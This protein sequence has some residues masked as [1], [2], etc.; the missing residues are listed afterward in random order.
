MQTIGDFLL[1]SAPSDTIRKTISSRAAQ[2]TEEVRSPRSMSL[3]LG[4]TG[5][6]AMMPIPVVGEETPADEKPPIDINADSLDTDRDNDGLIAKG[7]VQ[8]IQGPGMQFM[9]D[10]ARY[11]G[12]S[13]KLSAEGHVRLQH[14]GNEFAG[15]SLVLNTDTRIGELHDVTVKLANNGSQG[16]A[17]EVS[18]LGPDQFIMKQAWFTECNCDPPPWKV[19]ANEIRIDAV[20]KS[21]VASDATFYAGDFPIFWTPWWEQPLANQRKSGFLTPDFRTASG[22]GFE[23]EV[24]Y[25]FNLAPDHDLTVTLRPISNRGVLGQ[26]QV[27]YLGQGYQGSVQT[28]QIRDTQTESWRGLTTL[29]HTDHLWGWKIVARGEYSETRNFINDYHQHLVD[30]A[31]HRMESHVTA[32]KNTIADDGF[33]TM[34][35]GVRWNQDLEATNDRFTVQSLPFAVYSDSLPLNRLPG[36]G[37]LFDGL[38]GNR[39]RLQREF[40]ADNYYQMSGDAVQRLDAAPTLE[41]SRPLGVTRLTLRAQARETSYLIQGD[42]MQTGLQRDDTQHREASMF[43]ANL[44]TR[45]FKIYPG[46]AT[47]TLEPKV[48]VVANAATDQTLLPNYDTTQRYF[49]FS[50]LFGDSLYSGLDRISVGQRVNYALVTRLINHGE[51]EAFWQNMDLGVGQRWIPDDNNIY[52]QGRNFSPIVSALNVTLRGGW[53]IN[54]ANRFNPEGQR[55]ENNSLR[56]V[57]HQNK[58]DTLSLGY[59]YNQPSYSGTLMENAGSMLEDAVVNSHFHFNDQWSWNQEANYSLYQST[60]KSWKTGFGYEHQCWEFTIE[61][62]RKLANDTINHGGGFIGFTLG[63]KGIGDYGA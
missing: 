11:S 29:D 4:L 63:L 10:E 20:D 46:I 3:L 19:K 44:G 49:A 12:K 30:S 43:S 27:R 26:L 56:L 6:L 40:H 16:G 61:G 59:Y 54:A 9:A 32:S 1:I 22:N 48:E 15:R 55:I 5:L 53:E 38:D 34:R 31:A 8:I 50:N 39:W 2:V 62:G 37:G 24:P 17:E 45:L 42:P 60:I 51:Q 35:L 41:Y 28:Q 23:F 7:N 25:Y 18:L 58:N 52:Q 57:K 13:K 21:M 47:H 33:S 14:Q 36:G